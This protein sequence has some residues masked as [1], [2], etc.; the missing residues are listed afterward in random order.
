MPTG[1]AYSSE[2][3]AL[4]HLGP[5]YALLVVPYTFPERVVLCTSNIPWYFLDF[6]SSV[7]IKRIIYKFLYVRP[8]NY[9]ALRLVG[10][11]G[12]RKLV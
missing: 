10:R 8:F 11:L 3:L 5:A 12:S 4:S 1:D 6:D 7:F 9:I 2:H